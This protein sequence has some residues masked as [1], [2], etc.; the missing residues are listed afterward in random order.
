MIDGSIELF[1]LKGSTRIW[2]SNVTRKFCC[3]LEE[4][5]IFN[6]SNLK[7][8]D[9][10]QIMTIFG[11]SNPNSMELVVS[12]ISK[13]FSYLN[14]KDVCTL[15]I[16]PTLYAP[17]KKKKLIPA[18]SAGEM[19]KI[20]QACDRS[21][22]IGKRDY[23]ILL[24]AA[25]C[26]LRR[27]DISGLTLSDIDWERYVI[28]FLQKKTGKALSLPMPAE[29]GNAIAEYILEGRQE[30]TENER[31]FLTSRAPVR[32]LGPTAFNDL[33]SRICEKACIP[34]LPGR[35]FHSLRRS[36][37]TLMAASEVPVTT[38]SQVLGHSDCSSANRYISANPAMMSCSL[39]FAGIPITSEVYK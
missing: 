39:D 26:G 29:T 2:Y 17:C 13:F 21:T 25:S 11:K 35:N 19:Q 9:I 28:R 1:L 32:P 34:K 24:L 31:V 12:S 33:L 18:Y 10:S 20:L 30:G 7:L 15:Q 38:I 36:A 6:F 27:S 5:G 8:F 3:L 22:Q 16:E 23:A 37:G 14:R 4:K